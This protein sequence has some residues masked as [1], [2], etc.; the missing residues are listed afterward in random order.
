LTAVEADGYSSLVSFRN[1][2]HSA[3]SGHSL[4]EVADAVIVVSTGR[5]D[6]GA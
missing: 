2:R 3:M 6:G 5:P 4:A 1:V